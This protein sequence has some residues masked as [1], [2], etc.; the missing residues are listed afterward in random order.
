[1]GGARTATAAAW[2]AEACRPK[3]LEGVEMIRPFTFLLIALS[4]CMVP[5]DRSADSDRG[6][7]I[8]ALTDALRK[9]GLEVRD[10]GRVRQPFFVAP[11]HVFI[12]D[13]DDLQI[14]ELGTTAE[15]ETAVATVSADGMTIGTTKMHWLAPPHFFRRD[16]LVVNYL[17]TSA[18][19][20]GELE[21]I[22]GPQVAGAN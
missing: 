3:R 10:A 9:S 21:R 17:G 20:L 12:V 2:H 6:Q 16:R 14:Y 18:K 5:V 22:L 7:S 11:A 1:M 13:G 15:A 8:A 4:A 19:I